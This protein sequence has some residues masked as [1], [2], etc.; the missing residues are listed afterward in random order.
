[1][2]SMKTELGHVNMRRLPD[3][4][5]RDYHNQKLKTLNEMAQNQLQ[6]RRCILS[7]SSQV[8]KFSVPYNLIL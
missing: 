1:M 7:L 2:K 3:W 6:W 4:G 5:P 8:L